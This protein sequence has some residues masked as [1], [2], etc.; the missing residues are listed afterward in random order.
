MMD[1]EMSRNERLERWATLAE[2]NGA[3]TLMPF[4]EVEFLSNA[5]SAPLRQPNSPLALGY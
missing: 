4:R 2:Q 5:A 3:A 1:Q